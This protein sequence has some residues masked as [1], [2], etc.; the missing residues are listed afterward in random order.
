MPVPELPPLTLMSERRRAMSQPVASL[1][2]SV[3]TTCCLPEN[4]MWTQAASS[5]ASILAM[6]LPPLPAANVARPRGA[7]GAAPPPEQLPAE[8]MRWMS[9]VGRRSPYPVMRS[10]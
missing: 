3:G 1:V 9:K 6:V 2:G 4:W 8:V 7:T 10:L 5:L